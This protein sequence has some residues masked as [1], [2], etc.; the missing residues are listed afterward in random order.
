MKI[1]SK[2][3]LAAVTALLLFVVGSQTFAGT[4][5]EETAI[6]LNGTWRIQP[7]GGAEELGSQVSR[8]ILYLSNLTLQ[9]KILN[10]SS[11]LG[12]PRFMT[13]STRCR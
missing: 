5:A 7:A 8:H 11:L 10:I 3:Q 12:P 1:R 9:I 2:H 4:I 6:S 13:P